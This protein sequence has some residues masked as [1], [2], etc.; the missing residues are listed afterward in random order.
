MNYT[1]FSNAQLFE[2]IGTLMCRAETDEALLCELDAQLADIYNALA[3]PSPRAL[4]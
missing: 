4:C 1:S 3:D 2:G